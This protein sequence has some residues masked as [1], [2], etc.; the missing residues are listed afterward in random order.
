VTLSRWDVVFVPASD[1]DQFGHPAIVLSHEVRL[2]NPRLDRINVLMGTKKQPAEFAR[3][4]HVVLNGADGLEFLTLVDCSFVYVV[5]KS[6][7]RRLAGRV[8]LE[9]RK[10]IQRKTRAYLGLG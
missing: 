3:D 8:T 1:S 6:T 5:K 7:V 9:R 2:E 10:E 4:H